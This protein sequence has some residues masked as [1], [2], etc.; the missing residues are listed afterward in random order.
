LTLILCRYIKS[1]YHP[2]I[3]EQMMGK[4]NL[5]SGTRERTINR[6]QFLASTGAAA[7]SLTILRPELVRGT[8]LNSKI[9][10]GVIGCGDRGIWIAGL[11]Q[12]HGGYEICAAADYFQDRVEAFSAAYSVPSSRLFTG[13]SC[14]KR[15]LDSAAGVDAIAIESPPYFHPEQASAGV[16]AGVHVYLAKPVAVDVPG[17]LL[18]SECGEKASAKK[19]AFLVD[20]QTRAHTIFIEALKRLHEGALGELVFGEATYHA[21]CP[22]EHWYGLLII[23]SHN[24][25]NWI[26][27]WGLDRALSGDMITEQDIHALDVMNW[28]M[29]EPP[30][31]ALGT[32]GLKARP[33]IGTCWDH[34][35]VYYQ[36]RNNVAIQFSGRQFKG[37]GTSEGIKNRMFG[38]KGVLET[39]YGGTVLIRGENFY[40]GG[41]TS[42]IYEEG[43]VNNIAAF[44]KSITQ[45]DFSN[46]TV[47]PSVQS[48]LVAILGRKAAYENL[49][50]TWDELM[51]DQEKLVPNLKGLKD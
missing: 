47:A 7:L 33:K 25:E 17:A 14:Y 27:G 23:N 30:L 51:K 2:H 40:H 32:G 42:E 16:E 6:R 22:F 8:Q 43:V 46:P 24:P 1:P 5:E 37:H 15:L 39:E 31:H 21:D 13:L 19:R 10:L 35:V 28:V 45:G 44:Y 49:L 3:K 11:F 29:K 26:R 38:T 12:R 9:K 4:E 34:F 41:K 18:V 48:N 20:F 50:V 36:Y